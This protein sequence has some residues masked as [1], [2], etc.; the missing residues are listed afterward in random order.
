MEMIRKLKNAKCYS[1]SMT[2]TSCERSFSRLESIKSYVRFSTN[3]D[4]RLIQ[5]LIISIEN[6]NVKNIIDYND[7]TINGFAANKAR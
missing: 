7:I 6:K 5:L 3:Q 4:C 2:S 1:A